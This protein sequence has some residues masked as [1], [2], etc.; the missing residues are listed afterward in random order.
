MVKPI[1]CV[2]IPNIVDYDELDKIGENLIKTLEKDYYVLVYQ[3][4]DKQNNGIRFNCFHEKDI[5]ETNYEE[6]KEFVKQQIEKK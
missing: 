4:E 2:G 1:F 6:L 3:V 5:T